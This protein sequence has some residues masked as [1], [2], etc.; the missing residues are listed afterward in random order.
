M[1]VPHRW[2][3]P[4]PR[5]LPSI[6]AGGNAARGT[7]LAERCCLTLVRNMSSCASD[8]SAVCINYLKKIN[9]SPF[10]QRCQWK[11]LWSLT[12]PSVSLHY[13]FFP[14]QQQFS[15]DYNYSGISL[16]NVEVRMLLKYCPS[17]LAVDI[18]TVDSY[19]LNCPALASEGAHWIYCIFPYE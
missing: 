1:Q 3:L 18:H 6:A 2:V 9:L 12:F 10:F 19:I 5:C 11:I 8:W 7:Q 14:Q 16:I 15:E 4:Y 13:I 17:G